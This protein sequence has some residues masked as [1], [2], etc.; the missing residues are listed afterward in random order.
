[1]KTPEEY[2]DYLTFNPH[3]LAE[4]VIGIIKRVQKETWNEAID[5]AAENGECKI[6]L[7]VECYDEELESGFT[8][9]STD[10]IIFNKD[11]ILKL[12]I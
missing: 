10:S 5:K 3:T 2:L 7:T 1:M 8:V 9:S 6:K 12:K 11:S 4:E